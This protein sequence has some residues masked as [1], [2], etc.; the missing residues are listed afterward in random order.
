MELLFHEPWWLSAATEGAFQETTVTRNG[1]IVGRLPFIVT[2]RFGFTEIN[3]PAFTHIAGPAV[4]VGEGKQQTQ[5]IR[6]LSIVRE[7]ID[8]MPPFDACKLAFRASTADGLAFQDRG[9]RT[10]PQFTFQIDCTRDPQQLWQDMHFKTRQHIRRAEEK[11]TVGAVS[12]PEVFTQFYEENLR[13]TGRKNNLNFT[14]FGAVFRECQLRGCGDILCAS[15]PNGVPTAMVYVVWGRGVMYYLL[16]TRAADSGDNG[17]TCLLIWAAMKRAH[18][19]GLTLDL[20]G[21]STS[22]TAH[23]YSGFG[24]RL[25]MRLIVRR[26]RPIYSALQSAKRRLAGSRTNGTLDFT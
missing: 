3:M 26:A 20:D 11:F 19:L 1:R 8:R 4:N 13:K 5:L 14:A 12:D 6:R 25:D 7:L 23:F 22:G 17:S 15:W 21:V 2:R 16:A 9:Y 10:M 18:E 24:G